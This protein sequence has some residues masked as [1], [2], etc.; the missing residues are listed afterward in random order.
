M[1]AILIPTR[2]DSNRL[3]G[4]ALMK[5]NGKSLLEYVLE[6]CKKTKLIDFLG[7]ITTAKK[8]DRPI[9]DYF[10]N[11]TFVYPCENEIENNVLNRYNEAIKHIEE[12]TGTEITD[13]MRVTHDCPLLFFN[14]WIIDM[15]I[16]EHLKNN[17]DFTHNRGI[18]GWPSG[19]DVEIMTKDVFTYSLR[20]AN[21]EEKEHVTL[22]V[23][24][25][26]DK[27]KIGEFNCPYEFKGKFSVDNQEEFKKME[28]L[29]KL[30]GWYEDERNIFK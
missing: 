8:S 6:G 18:N 23:K 11:K 17:N 19:L 28:E 13:V 14:Y 10:F 9:V 22:Y 15:V 7:I 21:D 2:M 26:S 30:I 1:I 16:E 27:F 29:I 24:N 20:H 25:N 5:I 4:K 3:P 12:L